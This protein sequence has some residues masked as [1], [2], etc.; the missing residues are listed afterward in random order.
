MHSILAAHVWLNARS[1]ARGMTVSVLRDTS[2]KSE[3]ALVDIRVRPG[4]GE[5][6]QTMVDSEMNLTTAGTVVPDEER[7]TKG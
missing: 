5:R 1:I 4:R 2:Q 6:S 3:I 7:I